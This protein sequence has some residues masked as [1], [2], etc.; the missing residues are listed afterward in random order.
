MVK[1]SRRILLKNVLVL[2]SGGPTAAINAT[3][4]G[5]VE[6]AMISPNVDKIYGSRHGILGVIRDDLTEIGGELSS[7]HAMER[8]MFSPGAALGSCRKR[9]PEMD[10]D[11]EGEYKQI[12]ERLAQYNVGYLICV[13]GN[14]SMDTVVKL[15]AYAEREGI[16]DVSIVGAPKT[17]DNDLFGMDH[18]PGFPSAVRYVATTFTELWADCNVYCVPAVTIVEVMGRHVGWLA[19]S[20]ALAQEFSAA[21]SLIYLPERA[22]SKEQFI[23]DIKTKMEENPAVVIAISE[24]IRFA[25]GTLVAESQLRGSEDD[26]GHRMVAGASNVLEKIVAEELGCKVRSIQLSLMQRSA[27]HISS[28]VDL[29]EARMLGMVSMNTALKGISGEVSVLNRVSDDPYR[30]AYSTVP[31]STIANLEKGVP[32][33]WINKEGN[34]VTQ[35]MLDYLRPLVGHQGDQRF[36]NGIPNHFTFI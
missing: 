31:A 14:D 32:D 33:H 26:F 25:D 18:S 20:S 10:H 1:G 4:A 9:L 21:P 2:Q 13:G 35:E 16:S 3:L 7:P 30:V 8:L 19:A 24:G 15:A 12:F 28:S 6:R 34:G 11:P 23:Q 5:I 36:V 17:I 22:F 27:G 29:Y